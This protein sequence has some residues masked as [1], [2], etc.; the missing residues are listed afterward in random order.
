MAELRARKRFR[1]PLD[2]L[3]TP[4][5]PFH[6][7]SDKQADAARMAN[8]LASIVPNDQNLA[9]EVRHQCACRTLPV[10][11]H[12]RKLSASLAAVQQAQ[13]PYFLGESSAVQ[14]SVQP[15]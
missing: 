12:R 10:S 6:S 8:P 4:Y 5:P 3:P 1:S 2:I 13:E 9:C 11:F 7:E 14:Q 15:M